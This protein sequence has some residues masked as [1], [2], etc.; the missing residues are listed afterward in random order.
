M[1]VKDNA[2]NEGLN[3]SLITAQSSQGVDVRATPLRLTRYLAVFEI[4]NAAMVLR[5]SEI[6]SDFKIVLNDRTIYSGR[7][8]V[9]SLVSS[10]SGLICEVRLDETS[11]H[12]A[13]FSRRMR[14]CGRGTALGIS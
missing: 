14:T 3:N 8:V 10:G 7:A 11:F 9:S 4:Y 12:V 5:A 6:L 2:A 1:P 13:S